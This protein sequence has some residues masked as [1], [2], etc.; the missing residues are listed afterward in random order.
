MFVN[1]CVFVVKIFASVEV[2]SNVV[3][4]S[5]VVGGTVVGILRAFIP[6]IKS[7]SF[8][9]LLVPSLLERFI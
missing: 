5:V 8:I 6:P 4:I 1:G 3:T 7:K 9:F 2:G